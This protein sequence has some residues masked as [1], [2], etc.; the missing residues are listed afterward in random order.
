MHCAVELSDDDKQL[1]DKYD[2]YINVS[3]S[4]FGNF[5]NADK[6]RV[7][8]LI[9][10]LMMFITLMHYLKGQILYIIL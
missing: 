5:E 6:C 10:K 3:M 1:S 8:D 4:I 9:N 7:G 2:E